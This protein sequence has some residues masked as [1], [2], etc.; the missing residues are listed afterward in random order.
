MRLAMVAGC[1]LL[2]LSLAA[3]GQ[4]NGEKE[5]ALPGFRQGTVAAERSLERRFDSQLSAQNLHDWMR[6]LTA[7]PHH[8]G[9]A[10]DQDNAE[11]IAGLFRSWGYDTQIETFDVL[12]PTPKTRLLELTAP[13][14][15]RATL[16]EPV[17]KE[18]RT[19][20][21]KDQL[22]T[23]NAY[24]CDGDV[25]GPVVFVN[26]GVPKDYEQL[27]AQGVDVK[28]K[29]VLAK[30]GGSWRGIKPKVAFEHGAIGCLIY[31]DPRDDGYFQG[32]AYPKG[33]FRN[34]Y[35]AQRGSVVDMPTYPGD[36]LTP[37]V[38]ATKDAKRLDF[39][40]VKIFTKIPT[41][42]ISYT[43]ALPI[44]QSLTGPVAIEG[45]RGALPLT[46]HLG[47]GPAAVHLKLE[48]NW[49][50]VPAHDVI[51]RL[52]GEF[53]PD[54]WVLRGNHYDAWVFGQK[55]PSAARWRSWKRRGQ[56]AR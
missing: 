5:G 49:N 8:L 26:Y 13:G 32:D 3:L 7:R 24:S 11:F 2:A 54:E 14:R 39:K 51:A 52:P 48:F 28:G 25:T 45:W 37:G 12:F 23:Y 56:S 55:T 1:G 16:L 18:D 15:K 41:L 44:L 20:G 36:P 46:Y 29:I 34:E 19:S 9:S 38:G 47:P 40:D 17:L 33:P 50:R 27:E 42:P 35:G 21:V 43:D 4:G 30:Y 10:Y 6:R 31:S 53:L 22:P